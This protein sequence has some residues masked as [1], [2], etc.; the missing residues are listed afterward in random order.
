MNILPPS[1]GK[2]K[3]PSGH[4]QDAIKEGEYQKLECVC[5]LISKIKMKIMSTDCDVKVGYTCHLESPEGIQNSLVSRKIISSLFR[6]KF[7]SLILLSL[8]SH[9]R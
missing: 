9:L 1:S 5:D 6:N 4:K 3:T 2:E 7:V 8:P